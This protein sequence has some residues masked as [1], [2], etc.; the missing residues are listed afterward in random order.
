MA[1]RKSERDTLS[2]TGDRIQGLSQSRRFDT[3]PGLYTL[4]DVRL[5]FPGRH[6]F[7]CIRWMRLDLSLA[8]SLE[9][10]FDTARL[11]DAKVNLLSKGMSVYS[12]DKNTNIISTKLGRV[13]YYSSP[14][15]SP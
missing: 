13:T 15:A 5:Q 12:A 3:K 11:G 7:V 6:I 9:V 2:T 8:V 4:L 14:G 10:G 1:Q